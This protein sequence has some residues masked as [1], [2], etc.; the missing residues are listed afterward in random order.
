MQLACR[1][2]ALFMGLSS[3]WHASHSG[4]AWDR[5]LHAP[6]VCVLAD[7]CHT[8]GSEGP[9]MGLQPGGGCSGAACT[10]GTG[11]SRATG[12]FRW[13]LSVQQPLVA[14]STRTWYHMRAICRGGGRG[15][16]RGRGRRRYLVPL[17]VHRPPSI[18]SNPEGS[19]VLLLLMMT[20]GALGVAGTACMSWHQLQRK[21]PDKPTACWEGHLMSSGPRQ[22][23]VTAAAAAATAAGGAW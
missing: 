7:P 1:R 2:A 5:R 12:A 9:T 15:R 22:Q 21:R 10:C 18:D 13:A 3:D 6:A 8:Q 20:A 16:G 17:P 19:S 23:P 4:A 11:S 14:A